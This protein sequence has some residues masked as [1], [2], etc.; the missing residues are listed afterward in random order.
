MDDG[1]EI[2]PVVRID[3]PCV[4]VCEIDDAS[5]LCVGCA[6]TIDEIMRWSS[7]TPEWRNAVMRALP[8]RRP[9]S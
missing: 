6:R 1:F 8:A 2:V 9:T 7:G 3:S 5:G 4:N